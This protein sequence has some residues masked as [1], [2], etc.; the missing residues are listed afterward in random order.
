VRIWLDDSIKESRRT[1][2][3]GGKRRKKSI[4]K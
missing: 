1:M 2:L 4:N 3:K